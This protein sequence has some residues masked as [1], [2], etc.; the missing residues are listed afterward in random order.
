MKHRAVIFWG[1]VS[2]AFVLG[3]AYYGRVPER[4]ASHWNSLGEADGTMSRALGVF[5]IPGVMGI[6]ALLALVLPRI[7]P[8]RANILLF[9]K[10]FDVLMLLVLGFMFVAHLFILLWNTGTRL[11]PN[12]VF[13]AGIAALF[14]YVGVLCGVAKRNWSVGIRTPWTLSSD[15]VWEKTHRRAG[16]LFKI[17][18]IVI[19]AGALMGEE[20][21]FTFLLPVIILVP[22]LVFYSYREYRREGQVPPPGGTT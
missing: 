8:L 21:I 16:P 17:S 9:R 15:R 12:V 5:L 22:Y 13:P 10:Y 1:I 18:A 7:D 14:Y 20:A 6:V 3:V 2:L 11:S 4:M 19:L